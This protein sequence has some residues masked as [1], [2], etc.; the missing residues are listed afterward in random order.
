MRQG[1]LAHEKTTVHGGES[2]VIYK[3]HLGILFSLKKLSQR[4]YEVVSLI[5][6]LTI[7]IP[8]I[9]VKQC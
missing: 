6:A 4:H 8:L 2:P 7:I 3:L 1:L 9:V 5:H